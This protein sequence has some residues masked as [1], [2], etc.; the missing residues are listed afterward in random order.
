MYFEEQIEREV[1]KIQEIIESVLI[2]R[3]DQ[4]QDMIT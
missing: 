1:I 2:L 4:T 3:R